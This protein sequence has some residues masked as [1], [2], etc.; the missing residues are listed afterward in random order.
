MKKSFFKKYSAYCFALRCYF[1]ALARKNMKI[2][3]RFQ[4]QLPEHLGFEK[5]KRK[6]PLAD[7]NLFKNW[8]YIKT[9]WQQKGTLFIIA[10]PW[11]KFHLQ[12]EVGYALQRATPFTASKACWN[13]KFPKALAILVGARLLTVPLLPFTV[14]F[15]LNRILGQIIGIPLTAPQFGVILKNQRL[16]LLQTGNSSGAGSSAS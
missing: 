8:C 10:V 1:V 3:S 14:R 11:L 16:A 15:N 6:L 4:K 5:V 9:C 12:V 13:Y 7:V 2:A